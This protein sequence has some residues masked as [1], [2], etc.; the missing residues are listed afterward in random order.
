MNKLYRKYL[1]NQYKELGNLL[2]KIY[3]DLTFKNHCYW[4]I[5]LD[6]VLHEKWQNKINSPAYKNL[7]DHQLKLAVRKLESFIE[8][9]DSLLND[10]NYS[11]EKRR[12]STENYESKRLY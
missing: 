5:V 7:T 8:S 2:P 3:T 11:L 4:R 1:E 6:C 10:N 9:R 12:K